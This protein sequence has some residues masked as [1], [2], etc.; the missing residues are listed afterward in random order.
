MDSILIANVVWIFQVSGARVVCFGAEGRSRG[1]GG[2]QRTGELTLTL[3]F[4][5]DGR[6]LFKMN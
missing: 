6:T 1:A 4:S 3:C 5:N 2:T